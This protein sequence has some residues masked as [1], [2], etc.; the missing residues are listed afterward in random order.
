[1]SRWRRS[2]DELQVR[3]RQLGECER[4]QEALS[5]VTSC[6]QQLS[7]ALGSSCDGS[8]LREEME[9]SRVLA[10]KICC[11]LSRRLVGLLAEG[12]PSSPSP[13]ERESAERIWVLFL[14]ALEHF[15][16]DLQKASSLIGRFPLTQRCDRRALV[17]TG[18]SDT[19]AGVAACAA[20]VQTPWIT[21][22][23][24]PSPG[25]TNHITGLEDLLQDMQLKVSVPFWS[26][27]ATQQAWAEAADLMEDSVEDLMELEVVSN[28][29]KMNSCC[30]SCCRLG[31]LL[32]L[33]N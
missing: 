14:S 23:E 33:L 27:E 15:L 2:V 28:D 8:F 7:S 30:P 24:E 6:F 10:Y 18:S 32:Y 21:V 13:G 26:V 1:M 22:E 5:R 12:D 16:L 4:G 20:S 31:C 17:N 19:M 25:L 11:G 29:N 3:R 9:E